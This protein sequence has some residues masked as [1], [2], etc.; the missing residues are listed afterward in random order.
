MMAGLGRSEPALPAPF[1]APRDPRDTV[2]SAFYGRKGGSARARRALKTAVAN[3]STCWPNEKIRRDVAYDQRRNRSKRSPA[4]RT[5]TG[6]L[7]FP[8]R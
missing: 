8:M 3:G 1:A 5:C 2:I 7:A 4:M 6:L